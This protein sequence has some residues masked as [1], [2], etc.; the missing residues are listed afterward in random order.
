MRIPDYLS[1]IRQDVRSSPLFAFLNLVGV[2]ATVCAVLVFLALTAGV[3]QLVVDRLTREVDLLT[4]EVV[5]EN[6]GS[7]VSADSVARLARSV[8]AWNAVPVYA[9]YVKVFDAGRT[10]EV[11]AF[12]ESYA[13]GPLGRGDPRL[14]NTP[15][16]AGRYPTPEDTGG[17]WVSETL[18]STLFA[19]T[20]RV[21]QFDRVGSL[22]LAISEESRV[23]SGRMEA[24]PVQ[25]RGVLKRTP[26]DGI[27]VYAPEPL[28]A[29]IKRVKEGTRLSAA[30]AADRV[31]LVVGSLQEL[32]R[33]RE[34]MRGE[35]IF[36]RSV[37]SEE[38]RVGK[39]CRSRWSPY[40]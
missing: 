32:G 26:H 10:R 1:W 6:R 21:D 12:A 38:R 25:I 24:V 37:R 5:L 2:A 4:L 15:L 39:E 19:D 20:V 23:E 35:G 29:G 3:R 16:L 13:L 40:H 18:F 36:T 7:K 28:V 33:A 22:Y 27:V 34:A 9:T 17:V 31:D 14:A 8:G 11:L 30:P